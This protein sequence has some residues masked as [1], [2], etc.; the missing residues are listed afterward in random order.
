MKNVVS[1]A[2][3][4]GTAVCLIKKFK[5]LT[6]YIFLNT[7]DFIYIQFYSIFRMFYDIFLL[8]T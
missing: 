4:T 6:I 2:V 1:N 8:G 5:L 3:T 7:T